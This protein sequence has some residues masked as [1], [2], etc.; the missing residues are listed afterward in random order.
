MLDVTQAPAKAAPEWLTLMPD[1][2]PP[3]RVQVRAA[4]RADR[5]AARAAARATVRLGGDGFEG[6]V[7]YVLTLAQRVIQAWEGVG[8]SDGQP[9]EP[10]RD[11][12]IT[13]EETGELEDVIP[14]TISNLMNGVDAAFEA[15]ERQYVTPLLIAE[16]AAEAEKKGSSPS[17]PSSRAGAKK[18]AGSAGRSTAKPAKAAR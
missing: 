14:G 15:F 17:R 13:D 11:Q 12:V 2:D 3:V 8:D 4:T 18:T 16:Q 9:V 5:M 10:S 1:L 6:H 7:T